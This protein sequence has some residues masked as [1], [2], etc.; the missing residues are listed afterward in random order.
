MNDSHQS[1]NRRHEIEIFDEENPDDEAWCWS[2]KDSMSIDQ[3]SS[4]LAYEVSKDKNG[5]PPKH[6]TRIIP[7][8]GVSRDAL[9]TIISCIPTHS[10]DYPHVLQ[11]E[12][13][14]HDYGL[15]KLFELSVACWQYKCYIHSQWEAFASRVKVKWTKVFQDEG[16]YTRMH[17]RPID[18]MF[19]SIVF[20]WE[21]IFDLMYEPVILKYGN[22]SHDSENGLPAAFICTLHTLWSK[23]SSAY[24]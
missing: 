9:K 11:V 14:D 19:L 6:K 13:S 24:N 8:N 5:T 23:M 20:E 15:N 22:P 21:G 1:F 2:V 10:H 7:E 4:I 17:R 18:W 16:F 12:R 3:Y